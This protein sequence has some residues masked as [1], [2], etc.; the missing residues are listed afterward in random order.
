[1]PIPNRQG[2][3]IPTLDG[4]RCIAICLVLEAHSLGTYAP[5]SQL[6][7]LG[8]HGVQIFFVLSGYLITSTLLLESKIN[9]RLFYLRRFF[10]L[11]PAA[12]TYLIFLALLTLA[13][14]MHV[15][16]SSVWSCVFFY[17]NYI[18]QT[19]SN[20]CMMHFWSLS[21]EEQ[22]YLVWPAVLLVAGRRRAGLC[23]AAA[24]ALIA[25]YRVVFWRIYTQGDMFWR[26]EVRADSLL[27]GCLLALLLEKNSVRNWFERN[28]MIALWCAL[29]LLL[30]DFYCYDV[31]QPLHESV[32]IA[33]CIASTSLNSENIVSRVLEWP[34][35][36]LTGMASYSTY[37]WQGLFLR[38]N[39][40]VWGLLLLPAAFLFSWRFI[41]QPGIRL[42]RRIATRITHSYAEHRALTS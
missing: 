1:M 3:R 18:P 10:R 17:R 21:L 12:W 39:W 6:P 35:I 2:L 9:L 26:T 42:G 31:L 15:L 23:A 30:L 40:G 19:V 37:L 11:M 41:E 34:H 20:T 29:P 4:W 25:V 36:K 22:F 33:I 8:L 13:T 28:G 16:D 27:I 24:I 32:L 5:K 7:L 38:A 14:P